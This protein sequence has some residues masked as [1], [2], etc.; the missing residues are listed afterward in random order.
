MQNIADAMFIFIGMLLFIF[1]AT[2]GTMGLNLLMNKFP[3]LKK[4]LYKIMDIQ[5]CELSMSQRQAIANYIN[6]QIINFMAEWSNGDS[7]TFKIYLSELNLDEYDE[8]VKEE[9]AIIEDLL[10][11]EVES[12]DVVDDDL[13]IE[14]NSYVL[15]QRFNRQMAQWEREGQLERAEYHRS[16]GV[17]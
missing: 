14:V 9:I 1:L 10:L 13:Y 3:K 2:I 7:N 12:W 4:V 17:I 15:E 5:V 8:G 6:H 16:R 11:D